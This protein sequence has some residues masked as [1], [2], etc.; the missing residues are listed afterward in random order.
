MSRHRFGKFREKIFMILNG[1]ML[2][3]SVLMYA[4][5]YYE[6]YIIT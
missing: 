6:F 3:L 4:I 2:T 5:T 1:Q